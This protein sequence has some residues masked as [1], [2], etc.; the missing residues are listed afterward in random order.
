ML[1]GLHMSLSRLCLDAHPLSRVHA[2]PPASHLSVITRRSIS[3]NTY[4]HGQTRCHDSEL[5]V[6]LTAGVLDHRQLTDY[7]RSRAGAS[8]RRYRSVA[9]KPLR[10]YRL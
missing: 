8:A 6:D 3:N 4:T 2:S 10:S 5:L 7:R 9:S 1:A